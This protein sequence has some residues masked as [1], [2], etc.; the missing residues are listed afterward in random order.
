MGVLFLALHQHF[1]SAV[2]DFCAAGGRHEAPLGK[3][4]LGCLDG[5]IH[6]FFTRLL[7]DAYY[8]TSVGRITILERLASGR[9]DP[10]AVD[11]I[12]EDSCR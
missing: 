6:I 4:P 3:C 1:S 12:L 9:V 10:F 5:G 11:E 2:N 8:V 7:K